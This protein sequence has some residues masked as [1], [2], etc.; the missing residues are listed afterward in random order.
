MYR[1]VN[2]N[3]TEKPV[4]NVSD[5][6]EQALKEAHVPDARPWIRYLARLFDYII[7]GIVFSIA[8]AL[9]LPALFYLPDIFYSM[10]LIFVWIFIEARFL[11]WWGTTPGKWLL[12]TK[13][14][15]LNGNKLTFSQALSRSFAVWLKGMGIGFPI[16]SLITQVIAYNRLKKDG[17]TSWDRDGG[18]VVLHEKIGVLRGVLIG[19]GFIGFIFLVILSS[20]P[21]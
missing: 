4:Q 20:I 21:E 8:V 16:A 12:K 13:V 18:F 3:H 19:L 11:S 5:P 15:D 9:I 6:S 14:R 1:T 7:F 2:D 17:I 10:L